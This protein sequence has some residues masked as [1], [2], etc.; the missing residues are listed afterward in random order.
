M[1][2][3]PKPAQKKPG[4]PKKVKS[5]APAD[6]KGIITDKPKGYDLEFR[7]SEPSEFKK[8]MNTFDSCDVKEIVMQFDREMI[9]VYGKV[10]RNNTSV[11]K[12]ASNNEDAIKLVILPNKTYSYF[13][14]SMYYLRFK[15]TEWESSLVDVDESCNIIT[16]RYIAKDSTLLFEVS[17]NTVQCTFKH[18]I[19]VD[20]IIPDG[21]DLI[22]PKM[23]GTVSS[24]GVI[25]ENVS[26]GNFKKI[27]TKPPRKK[28]TGP[29]IETRIGEL[30]IVF[31][32]E[33]KHSEMILPTLS[34]ND[35]D[36]RK[37]SGAVI[38]EA[39]QVVVRTPMMATYPFP[40]SEITKFTTHLKH[41]NATLH[42]ASDSMLIT[43]ISDSS[44]FTYYKE[45]S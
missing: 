39:I 45:F 16:M 22:T 8:F 7:Y 12:P 15:M 44:R 28:S 40:I 24:A 23:I 42:F 29:R 20:S 6:F 14:N 36:A 27:L 32:I 18:V 43:I 34:E 1:S 5:I 10:S 19:H 17:N 38:K 3:K 41:A 25:F 35:Y 4:R 26:C 37:K 13:C 33:D 9:R 31:P 21:E 30:A 2:T 11:D